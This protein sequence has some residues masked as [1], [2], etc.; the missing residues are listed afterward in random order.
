MSMT[1]AEIMN[2]K[3]LYIGDEDR[4]ALARKHM[5]DFG[6]A[7]IPVLDDTHRPVGVVSLRDLAE[8]GGE[9]RFAPAPGRSVATI[10]AS[11]PVGAAA[12]RLAESHEHHLV[13]VDDKGVAVGMVSSL[14]F[15]RALLGLPPRHP[16]P[17]DRF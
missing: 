15:L 2:P 3:L 5:V 6:V 4:L 9:R 7:A 13:V 1:V 17:F 11:E 14:D 12:L 8:D 16:E 10:K